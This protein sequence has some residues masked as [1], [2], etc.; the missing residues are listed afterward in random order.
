VSANGSGNV[1]LVAQNGAGDNVTLN[2]PVTSGAGNLSIFAADSVIQTAATGNILTGGAGTVDVETG[3]GSITMGA[4]SVT[5]TAGGNIRYRAQTGV[6]VAVLDARTVADRAGNFLTAQTTAPWGSESVTAVT[7][8]I[9]NSNASGT[10]NI[11]GNALRL[12][13]GNAIGA[14]GG[15]VKPL[16]TEVAVLSAVAGAGGINVLE[17]SNVT[18]DQVG[19]VPVNQ[20]KADATT[21]VVQNTAAQ[22]DLTTS[23][24]GSIV[25]VTVAGSITV[26]DG[27]TNTVG[28][29]AN[30]AGNI[31]LQAQG[32]AGQNVTLNTA[33][34]SGTGN[35]S[36]L[37]SDSVNQNAGGNLTTSGA[38]TIQVLATTG[39]ITMASTVLTQTVGGNVQY[40]AGTSVALGMID[41]HNAG[42]QTTWGS[43]SIAA[44]TGSITNN[45][46]GTT[47]NVN[48][49]ALRLTA[50]NAIGALGGSVKPLRTEVV[51]LSALA[52]AGG[53]NVLEA[54]SVTVTLVAP[55]TVSR[56]NSDASV[57]P[58]QDAAA[59]SDLTSVSNAS[60]SN[61]SIVLVTTVGSI[62]V[63][64]GNANSVG[65]SA[66]GSGNVL[67]QAQGGVGQSVTLNTVVTS[68]TGNLSVLASDSVNQNAGG[69]MTTSGAGTVQVVATTGSI[70]MASTVL[71]QTVG[72]NVQYVAGV[73]VALGMID[74]HNAGLQTTWGSVSIAAGTGSITNN[75]AGTT[76]NVNAGA[77][78]LTAGNAIGALGGGV[79]P[80]RT[81]VVSLSALA[82]AGGINVLEATSVTVTLVAPVAVNR[83]NSDASVTPVQD[84]AAQSDLTSVSNA[85]G[86]NGSIVLVTTVGSITVND[87]DTNSVGVSANGS[88]NVLLQAQ[89]GVGQS[90]TLN[91]AVT[92]GTGN[93]S[94]LASD[95]VNQN[96]GGNL[97][98]SGAGTIQVLATT[99]SITMASTV[100]TQ[101]VG[102]NVQ[103][104]AGV[105]VALGMIDTHTA[106]LPTTWGSV[107]VTAGTGSI[108]NN[109]A[110][111]TLN[112]NASAL[113]LTAGNA[114]GAL[115]GGVKPLRTEVVTLSAL[116]GAGGINV[117]EAT[118]VTVTLVAPV[119][120]SQVK[121]DATTTLVQDAAAQSDLTT[122]SGGGSIVLMTTAG[123]IT[124]NDG[125]TNSVGVSANGAGNVLL[126]AQGGVGQ[127]V[128]LNTA[129]T[130]GT[131][132]LSVLASDSVNQNAGGNLT[133][134]GAGTVDVVATTGS[135]TMASAVITQ[136][137][138]GNIRYQAQV[139]VAVALLDG[140]TPADRTGG[141]LT[142]QTA[143]PGWASESVTAVTGSIT[144]ANASGTVNIYG[145]ALRLNAGNAIGALGAGVKP[146][147]TEVAVLSASAGAG[148]V[149]VLE[150][151]SV[152]VDQVGLVPVSQVKNDATTTV[153][154]DAG[155]QSDVTT[156]SGG[157]IVLVTVAGSITINDGNANGI[158]VSANA[159]GNV[160]VQAQGG[161]VTLNPALTS[162]TGNLTVLASGSVTQA[163]VTG[164]ILTG[165]AG[166]VDVVATAGS[167][168]MGAGSLT[169]TAGG[170]IRYQAQVN[171][172]VS[173]LDGRTA[174][175][176]ANGVLS[177]QATA[178]GSESVTAVTGS[179]TNANAGGTVNIY[180]NTLRLN[181]GGA[182]GKLGGGTLPLG[183]EVAV[184]S[185][186]AGAGGINVQDATNV[187]VDQVFQ[188][189]VSQVKN[190]GT[191]TVAQD[192]A[193]QS[194]LTTSSNGS[195][196]LT[197][198]TGSIT[199]NDGNANSVGVSA[200]GSGNVLL[201]AQSGAGNS[202]TLNSGVASGTGNLTVL[203]ADSVIQATGAGNLST[204]GAGTVDVEAALGSITMG[205]GASTVTGGG[206]IRYVAQVNVAVSIITAPTAGASTAGVSV[207]A[208]T[209]SITNSNASGTVN[210]TGNALR[211][212][213]GNAIGALGAGVKPLG[214]EVSVLAAVAGAGGI[215]VLE[216][217][218]VTVDQVGPVAVNQVQ[219][220]ATTAV[221]QNAAARSDL[222][223][224]GGGS[225]VL[226]TVAGSITV[227]DGDAN[228][229]GVS[230]NGSGNVLLQAQGGAG[231]NVNLNTAVTS[232]AGN[233][234]V[235][236]SDSVNQNA[237]GNLS[238][239]GAGTVQVVATTGSITMA[240]TVLT[241]TVGGN[242]QYVAGV[243]VALGMIDTHNAGLPSTWGSVS[244]AA[245]T[246]SITNNHAGTT[247]NVNAN[248]L[249][250]TAGNAIGAL[251]GGVKPLRTE[252]VSLS[253]LAGAGGINVLEATSVTV[254][255][256]APVTVSQVK[257][258]ATTTLVQDAAAQSDLTTTSGGGSIVLVTTVGSITVND[259]NANS[260][261]V[262]ANGAGNILLQAQGGV[263]QSVTLNTAVTSGAG[264]LSVLAS[265]SVNQNAG[266]NLTTSGAGTIQVV[267]TTGSI[268]MASTVLTQ[269]VGGN[270]QYVA[271]TSV[272][273]GMID[274][275]N[276][277]LPSTW[278]SV[279]IAAGTGSITNNNAGTTLNV[280]ANALRL[281]AGNA[282][283]AL[284]AGAKPVRTEVVSLSALAGAGGL[285]VLEAT[286]V[287]VTL[288]APVTV[289]QVNGDA[290]VTA[291]QDAAAQS[292]L[293]TSASG[294]IVL[295]TTVGSITVNDG[296]ANSVGV[297]AN[298]SGNV[299]LQAQGGA[300]QSV[301]LDSSVTSGTGN[302]TVLASDSV[303]Q[304]AATG[305]ILTGGAGTVD[306]E[307]TLGSITMGAGALTQ[308]AGGNI[309]Y[310]AQVNV[311][312][313]V[314]DART[315]ADRTGGTL[316]GQTTGW[317]TESVRAAT[318]SITNANASGT[319][320]I[321]GNALRLSAGNAIGKL[322][323]GTLPLG[324]EVAV[325]SAV[326]G[327]GG[328]NVLEATSVT[329]DQVGPVPVSQ[330]K[331][332][333]TTQVVQNAGSRSDL[334]TTGGGSIVLVTTAGSITV[335]DGD[336]NS[337]GVSASGA[338][339][340]LLQAQG[341]LGNSVTLNSGVTSG[342]GN[343]SVLADDSVMQAAATGNIQTGGAGTVD[344]EA[345]L[346][347]ITMGAGASTVTAGG[348]IRYAAQVSVALGVLDARSAGAQATW[349]S[350]SVAAGTASI[351]NSNASGT[352]N[353]Y[354]NALRLTAGNGLGALGAGVDPLG[355]EA[356]EL[357][358]LA[359]AGGISLQEATGVTVDQ[360]APVSVSQVQGDATTVAVQDAAAQADLTT[361][362]GSG[363]SIVLVTVNGSL[364]VNDGD[365]NGVGVSADGAG[366][367]RLEAGGAGSS[368]TLNTSVVSGSG[369]LT[370]LGAQDVS[371]SAGANLL[372][373]GPGTV[374]VEAGTGSITMDGNSLIGTGSGNLRLVAAVN[375]TLG[376][377]ATTGNVG[378]SAVAGSIL[379][380]G[381]T[382]VNV[383]ASGLRLTAGGTIGT[384]QAQLQLS[385]GTLTVSSGG[386]INLQS[387][388]GL[389]I[390][391]VS[392]NVAKVNVDGTTTLT[393]DVAQS[394]VAVTNGAIVIQTLAG[395]LVL[396]AGQ[397]ITASGAN[398]VLLQA[399]GAGT[400]VILNGNVASSGGNLTLL[401]ALNVSLTAGANL[402][403]T[404]AG[405]VDVEAG[406]GS[407]TLDPA[408]VIGSGSGNLRL[409]AAVKVTLGSLSTGGSVSVTAVSGSILNG[410][411][412]VNL[413]AAAAR[414]V[415]GSGVGQL[416]N[417]LVTTLGTVTALAGAGGVSLVN[418]TALTVDAVSVTVARVNADGTASAVTD[419][420]QADV[421]T[422]GGGSIVIRTQAG[423][424]TLNDGDFNGL[425]VS[426]DGAG[427]V[428]LQAAGGGTVNVNAAARSGSGNLT[429]LG[430]QDVN[431]AASLVT[432]GAGTVDV[433]AAAGSLTMNG[434]VLI[435]T[436][437]GDL[438][439][440]AAGNVTLGALST[441]GSVGVTASTGSILNG[442]NAANLTASGARLVAGNGI[443]LPG[444][445]LSL[446][447]GTLAAL[448]GAGGVS[449]TNAADL[450][451]DR[452]G[453]TVLRVNPDGT[454]TV[455]TDASQAD[456]TTGAG[457]SILL[458]VTGNLTLND[459]DG[460]GQAIGAS[461]A[462]NVR[463]QATGTVTANA[464]LVSG[465][466]NV[467]VLGGQG[468]VFTAGADLRTLG[469]GTVEIEAGALP[470][471]V[472]GSI[473][474]DGN[475]LITSGTGDVRLVAVVNVIL[476]GVS[477]GGDVSVIAE[478]GSILSGGTTYRNLAAQGARLVAGGLGGIGTAGAPL[479]TAVTTLT[480]SAGSGGV[481][482]VEADALTVDAVSVSVTKVN[483]DGTTGTVSDASQTGVASVNNGNIVIQTLAGTLT[484]NGAVAAG[485]T[486]NVRLQAAGAGTS[487]ALNGGVAGNN[488]SVLGAQDVSLNGT[489]T[490]GS[491]GPGTVDVEA[492][493]GSFTMGAAT[494][495]ESL[496]G[497]VRL[498]A[499]VN[500]TLGVVDARTA[501]DQLNQT[502][503]SE[504]GW[505][506]VEVTAT[507][508]A[509]SGTGQAI[510]QTI[511]AS[512]VRLLAG[513]NI[514][515]INVPTYQVQVS[516]N[517]VNWTTLATVTTLSYLD[518]APPGS[519]R[520]YRLLAPAGVTTRLL[521]PVMVP[522]V[523]LQL[524]WTADLSGFGTVGQ[525]LPVE[526]L[527]LSARSTGGS[528]AVAM[529]SG[530]TVGAVASPVSAV[531]ADGTAVTVNDG[532]QSD[533][534]AP[535]A[536]GAVQLSSVSGNLVITDGDANGIGISASGNV[537][538]SA[539]LGGSVTVGSGV[540][541]TLGSV[542]IV[543]QQD[544]TQTAAGRLV[545]AA[546]SID[547]EAV[548][549]SITMADGAQAQAGSGSLRYDAAV[550]ATVTGLS[551][552]TGSLSVI[553]VAGSILDGG[554][555]A[556]D[557]SGAA[558]RLVAGTGIGSSG[559]GLETILGTVSALTGSGIIR[560]QNAGSITVGAVAVSVSQVQ[561]AG[562]VT[563]VSDA[564]Q[565][566]LV[567]NGGSIVLAT[568][569]GSITVTD[570]NGN[571]FGV[572]AAGAGN[573]LL[574]AGGT[575]VTGGVIVQSDVL[576]AGTGSITVLAAGG[577]T[578]AGTS[579][580]RSA[581]GTVDVQST[582]GSVTMANGSVIQTTGGNV[583]VTAAQDVVLGLIDTR[584]AGDRAVNSKTGQAAWGNVS[585]TATAGSILDASATV[586][587]AVDVYA[588][589]ARFTAGI[590][591]GQNTPVAHPIVTELI[592]LSALAGAGGVNVSDLAGI[593]VGTVAGVTANRVQLDGTTQVVSD[594][595]SQTGVVKTGG[596]SVVQSQDGTAVANLPAFAI[597]TTLAAGS[598]PNNQTG[599]FE[600][601]V[602]VSNTTGSTIDAVRV[603]VRNLPAGV[604][605]ADAAGT[606]A[607]GQ[608]IQYNQ[609]LAAGATVSLVIEYFVPTSSV[610]PTAATFLPEI[611]APLPT[612]NP[613]GTVVTGVTINRLAN[614]EYI[615]TL[616]TTQAG[617]HYFIQYS[618]DGGVT[619]LT[620]IP[621]L[622]GTGGKLVWIDNGPPK[623]D[624]DSAT[625]AARSY[626]II[627]S[628]SP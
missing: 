105:N 565:S 205:A 170:N 199:I 481:Y 244:I 186:V 464:D 263:G 147:G 81:E 390:G 325:L 457:G 573:V 298:G 624:A 367:V 500:V 203:A 377:L 179:I 117:L 519:F 527:T 597:L 39:S 229:V 172:I 287:T 206:N 111:T 42:L 215:N 465:G 591:V 563:V 201:Q 504:G 175:D 16:G 255:L 114:I 540:T 32:G 169:Q 494:E 478:T 508:G 424:L 256:V 9:T 501:A 476:G 18:V 532:S 477:T 63:N 595:G 380:G 397:T 153:V 36:V 161:D 288:V 356:V 252:V 452:V 514:G 357:S 555:S 491:A 417:P 280:N 113:R 353:I 616:P 338:G 362:V 459:G 183:T 196:V 262:S 584:T 106:G 553:A 605:V 13:A 319:V 571:G 499:A 473:V 154:Q 67:L 232:G 204:G 592:T 557:L 420:S 274:T 488:V 619:W 276:A 69:N 552:A 59:Q 396:G 132:N 439:L 550:T 44:G 14:L 237:G 23:G 360:V 512:G 336:A 316:A 299:L 365:G 305:N 443:G 259:G 471:L 27:D 530:V 93:L 454:T 315:V 24:G 600:Q 346:G 19:Q 202:V 70:T 535:G 606:D 167:I 548:T 84:A 76:L 430:A 495:L 33:V 197:T 210:I 615:L 156:S 193:V 26:N 61:G 78:R 468:V 72:G 498:V 534:S 462:G 230:A 525:G 89:G 96:A 51:S 587:N 421:V 559:N 455:V 83:V 405:T 127:S 290:S 101:T 80:L 398:N 482:V 312:V 467:T 393:T 286:S 272:A 505:G 335:N 523:G 574:Q 524:T 539:G 466:G 349:G 223:T 414:L 222:T 190:D 450:T 423:N 53:I 124:V 337:V 55:V 320:N 484:V 413:T 119:T 363:G 74:T 118:S 64:D 445:P 241:Q 45:N 207:T 582:G 407:I 604:L 474:M 293:T 139:N 198:V 382:Y 57:T 343:I 189:P 379:D 386:A 322:G 269:T 214:T 308:T 267:A 317:G 313:A 282:I 20:V 575:S 260:V 103:Y 37:A 115:G 369:N 108:T 533:V 216:A 297:N 8:S 426:A 122:A 235:L 258:D 141:V 165:G 475:S 331:N 487:V 510:G 502:R 164:N 162:G 458:G 231:Q 391:T 43:V 372:S 155:L 213:A 38:G 270:V 309:R 590:S 415:A 188:V 361:T 273:L 531:Q 277:G 329:V 35:L 21:Q 547:V 225:I 529:A 378:V 131:G 384:P 348:N 528:V 480:A 58:V 489:A 30:G 585:V 332:D 184:V 622:T 251:G 594:A 125:N 41:T 218:S 485:G 102:G 47:L 400:S 4:G 49:S 130:S 381:N 109:N 506:A 375:V 612:P 253:A 549:G 148:G 433:E 171:V 358:A 341:G 568:G 373:S 412:G 596:L 34:T 560:I 150:A 261:G 370:V 613:T 236:A 158:G 579:G 195:I 428:L 470:G 601:R 449:V 245:G 300:G 7:G 442:G 472:A 581:G 351:T 90:V 86:S 496:G 598:L 479:T 281:T 73:S 54:T 486:G 40:V 285:D 425:S 136:T 66:N 77:L 12:M 112:V 138:G 82:G 395:D 17:A 166:T 402:T 518:A 29:S 303:T 438:R 168:T 572:R 143:V 618:D 586:D 541:S 435:S 266:G 271:G 46:A 227:N 614:N 257:N 60:G 558:A 352:V 212:A 246:G 354:A 87:G 561:A 95:S 289:S 128:T 306:V 538:V 134:S 279:S 399:V 301:T 226:V 446:D 264:N 304:A 554:D 364:T 401:G 515:G 583:R 374:D 250:L 75:N 609:P 291:V 410:G 578:L 295:V 174:L 178:W 144:N 200:S 191:T 517:L 333:G 366:N 567:N 238:T 623:T 99:G 56:V 228:N 145:N 350:V 221:V 621:S 97:T 588:A 432:T 422:S 394:G 392:A 490:I 569:A 419:A 116:A 625:V 254:T 431:L 177:L 409:V 607:G 628:T 239:S 376:G 314:L 389:T 340:V 593:A 224:S 483:A 11:Y 355:T 345:A 339:N 602:S 318:G 152:T 411:S 284:G 456:V 104:V 5:Q 522:G 307:A 444:T 383:T 408:S 79:K 48:A 294:S 334:T 461:G 543:A 209:G 94:V 546:G 25:L 577:V 292:D 537:R 566:D 520:F 441:A 176:R 570:G 429:V 234:S 416:S 296:D 330:V 321:Y 418:T 52:G 121:N 556:P 126:Q 181:A 92:S 463:L 217:T 324:T 599:L 311:V 580:L 265:D 283:G 133:T 447:V 460:N 6:A 247:L 437:T 562:N 242:V 129:V 2:S 146:L 91:T 611:T 123:S 368:V 249:R 359:G 248:A 610:V 536:G 10:V 544:V 516:T 185:A 68:G 503:T 192:A 220:D 342:T 545:V 173:V 406:T 31:L 182:I 98:T 22:A 511:Y 576:A 436:D 135:I 323:S 603:Y 551:S 542:T 100:L 159:A 302:V 268:T 275:H 451:V 564:A 243:S 448:A 513:G 589:S 180:G 187:T 469:A 509:I 626:R 327:A 3:A 347:S 62:T 427:N 453:V 493:T 194:D 1:Q 620:A 160:L 88:G 15:G 137:A 211:L 627:A 326:A 278:G 233:L 328:I 107:S 404:G 240:S 151:T 344:V 521:T 28:V 617:L 434:N 149:N 50:G 507:T 526:A 157:S 440:S 219:T 608:F 142:S 310:A 140:R 388:G 371:L 208:L 387:N 163:A 385:V 403:T 71:T 492:G 85:S 120:V 497:N 65:V 110:G